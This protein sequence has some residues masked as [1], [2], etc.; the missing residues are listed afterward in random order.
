MASRDSTRSIRFLLWRQLVM[1]RVAPL[2]FRLPRAIVVAPVLVLT[3]A[4]V[5]L[6]PWTYEPT[7]LPESKA[8]ADDL[9]AEMRRGGHLEDMAWRGCLAI[10]DTGT[11]FG[12]YVRRERDAAGIPNCITCHDGKTAQDFATMWT[13]FP[14]RDPKSGQLQDFAQAIQDEVTRRYGGAIPVRSDVAVSTL[15]VYA[16]IKAKQAG[17]TFR[18]DQPEEPAIAEEELTRLGAT[19][20]CRRVFDAKGVP[21]GPNAEFI[22]RGCNLITDTWNQVYAPFRVWRTD[23]ICESCHREAGTRLHAGPLALGAVMLPIHMTPENKP[24]RFDRRTL[25]CFARSLNWL[26]IGRDARLLTY[27]NVYA[28]W[29][30]QRDGYKIGLVYPGRGIPMLYDTVGGGSSILAGEKVYSEHCLRCHGKNAWGGTSVRVDGRAPPPIAGPNAFNAL[31][32]TAARQRLAGFIHY[33]MPP[34]ATPEQ[35][36]LNEQQAL[37]VAIYLESLGRPS[38]FAHVSRLAQFANYVWLNAVYYGVS[39]YQQ[40][41]STGKQ[42]QSGLPAQDEGQSNGNT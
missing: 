6:R 27:I 34:G 22:V 41:I 40:A 32:T 9:G 3:F 37:D 28:N 30:A 20:P 18:M 19:L 13:Y 14:R 25:M 39:A 12:R 15:Y 29:L 16:F 42:S 17:Y 38:D 2:L 7:D 21:R 11:F 1:N 26:D 8:C 23:V 4:F 10:R 5:L 31:A 35:P 24:I 33:N 36:I